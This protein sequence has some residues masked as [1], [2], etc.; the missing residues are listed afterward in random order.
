MTALLLRILLIIAAICCFCQGA[1]AEPG[2]THHAFAQENASGRDSI[3]ASRS[4]IQHLHHQRLALLCRECDDNAV[5]STQA[6]MKSLIGRALGNDYYVG[7]TAGHAWRPLKS[8]G[9]NDN[10]LRV[11]NPVIG[12]MLKYS[13]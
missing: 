13:F 10:K 5:D 9:D 1:G 12:V 11:Y 2:S 3:A 8:F 4:L 7:I 6:L